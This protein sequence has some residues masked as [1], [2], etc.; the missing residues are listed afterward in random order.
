MHIE[1]FTADRRPLIR[2]D[3]ESFIYIEPRSETRQHSMYYFEPRFHRKSESGANLLH[4]VFTRLDWFTC[5][6]VVD[7]SR[8]RIN[9]LQLIALFGAGLSTIEI[10]NAAEC[11]AI[12]DRC[13]HLCFQIAI[14]LEM[15]ALSHP[16]MHLPIFHFW[17]GIKQRL[18]WHCCRADWRQKRTHSSAAGWLL[19]SH[20][21]WH[22][23]FEQPRASH[24]ES[25]ARNRRSWRS[26]VRVAARVGRKRVGCLAQRAATG[27]FSG[28]F[29]NRYAT[30][31]YLF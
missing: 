10:V 24:C 5:L 23:L 11:T 30:W 14:S 16:S 7:V 1:A 21:I 31:L 28:T 17:F 27:Q 6:R 18:V 20:P 9:S 8:T 25:P 12:G 19:G 15:T 2:D 3:K 4:Q 13:A 29:A 22:F 26:P